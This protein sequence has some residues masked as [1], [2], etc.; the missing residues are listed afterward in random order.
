MEIFALLVLLTF[1]IF[2]FGEF[3]HV[4]KLHIIFPKAKIN[5]SLLIKLFDSTAE[6]QTLYACEQF[7][8]FG[9]RFADSICFDCTDLSFE[10]YARCKKICEKYGIII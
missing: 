8:W 6:K 7:C 10:V 5:S 1:A 9:S 3:L 2:G 4:I